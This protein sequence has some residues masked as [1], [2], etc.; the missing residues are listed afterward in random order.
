MR[1]RSFSRFA[2]VLASVL[3]AGLLFAPAV[4][5]APKVC[6]WIGGE[7]DWFNRNNWKGGIPGSGYIAQVGNAGSPT[8]GKS[9]A[10]ALVL[11]QDNASLSLSALGTLTLKSG[12]IVGVDGVGS[13]TLDGGSLAIT[14]GS[15]ILAQNEGAVGLVSM[16]GGLL[17]V[18]G[19][20]VV[21]L[22]SGSITTFDQS[23]GTHSVAGTLYLAEGIDALASYYLDDGTLTAGSEVLG[24]DGMWYFEQNAGSHVVSGSLMAGEGVTAS[25][26]YYLN[27][28]SLTVSGPECWGVNGYSGYSQD[29]GTHT[30]QS[31]ITIGGNDS[32]TGQFSL[33]GGS[34]A[35]SQILVGIGDGLGWLDISDP[36]LVTV[37]DSITFGVNSIFA[38]YPGTI[39]MTGPTSAFR[40]MSIDQGSLFGLSYLNAMFEGGV[41]PSLLPSTP[42]YPFASDNPLTSIVFNENEVLRGFTV[43]VAP[44]GGATIPARI[45]C[46]YS[47][48]H[49]LTLGIRQVNVK[50]IDGITSTTYPVTPL[51]SNPGSAVNPQVGAPV[52][53]GGTDLSG[54]PMFPALFVTDVTD[55]NA[56]PLAG[57]WQYGGTAI[58]PSA[59]Y[60]TWKAAVKTVDKTRVPPIV[61]VTP[62]VDPVKNGWNLGPGSD[63][64]PAGLTGQGWG[65]EIQWDVSKLGLIPGH[66]YRFYFM[67]HDGDQN[68]T[69][70][71]VGHACTTLMSAWGG[72]EVAGRDAGCEA[73][74]G[75]PASISLLDTLS[76]GGEQP[77][78]VRL[79]DE[80]DNGG[81]GANGEAEALYVNH[82]VVT[83]GSTLDL[84]GLNVYVLPKAAGGTVEVNGAV[85]NGQITWCEADP[86]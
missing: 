15:L 44:D 31:S 50:T 67:V 22:G 3:T 42:P 47:D 56:N 52:A 71:D 53:E 6:I 64:V 82:I 75:D 80:F 68:K 5:A 9:G 12:A 28:G 14:A 43:T 39:H 13:L 49:A 23:A 55:P 21:G 20:E 54:R 27:G 79:V 29:G 11:Q 65:A 57:D 35:A 58:L 18:A 83:E 16:N 84:N 48:E 46:F 33:W 60:G 63:P 17:S 86:I 74:N 1:G 36:A 76:V 7:G 59:V 85:I 73:F 32:S 2:Y 8:I 78:N 40:N 4:S 62:D 41:T 77:A 38:T 24:G 34:L 66:T 19:D 30:A 51:T 69:G 37:T 10:K 45:N 25:G 61:T 26:A 70:G 72:Y 81:R